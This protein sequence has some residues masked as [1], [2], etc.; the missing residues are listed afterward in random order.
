MT[1]A[2]VATFLKATPSSWD[3]LT[4]AQK[5]N[6]RDS[7]LP[8]I[9]GFDGEQR[10]WFKNWWLVCTQTQVDQMNAL[11]PAG[12]RVAPI[13]WAAKLYLSIDL[14]TDVINQG[15]TYYPARS[16]VRTLVCTFV[17]PPPTPPVTAI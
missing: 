7:L 1:L 12:V 8:K 5:Q 15:D 13:A 10:T 9:Q 17:D 14:L 2:Q 11:L 16:V 4:A 3:M 6:A